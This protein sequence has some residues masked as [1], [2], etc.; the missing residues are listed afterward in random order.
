MTVVIAVECAFAR[1]VSFGIK[2]MQIID[3][4]VPLD[5]SELLNRILDGKVF[6]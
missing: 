5:F 3:S 6:L 1:H 2:T 4:G